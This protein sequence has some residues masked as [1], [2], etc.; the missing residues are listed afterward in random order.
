VPVVAR[1]PRTDV[2]AIDGLDVPRLVFPNHGDVDY[3]RAVLDDRSVAF[4]LTS[5]GDLPDST[6]RQL[7]WSTL[8]DM[9]REGRLSSVDYLDAVGRL[10]PAEQDEELTDAVLEYAVGGLTAYVPEDLRASRAA[11]LIERALDIAETTGA[12]SDLRRTWLRAAVAASP[13]AVGTHAID[14]LLEVTDREDGAFPV[15]QDLRWSLAITASAAGRADAAERVERES[16]RDRS[17]R[18]VRARLT[19][20]VARPDAAGKAAAWARINGEGYGSFQLTRAAMRGFQWPSQRELLEPFREAFFAQLRTVFA[21]QE[22]HFARAWL[23]M[24]YPGLWAEPAMVERARAL[25]AELGPDDP[26]LARHLRETI[27]DQERMIRVRARASKGS[28]RA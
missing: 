8:W 22:Y 11:L 13:H 19:A 15:D 26:V 25:L 9:V 24:L 28:V 17:D 4:A 16:L 2:A 14:W 7:L 1:G 3:A 10:L 21:E 5:L 12:T 6:L 20:E 27:D 23:R 18:G